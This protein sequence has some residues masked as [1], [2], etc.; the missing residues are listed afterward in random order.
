VDRVDRPVARAEP[1]PDAPPDQKIRIVNGAFSS[2]GDAILPERVNSSA[3]FRAT[4]IAAL[5][6]TEGLGS[7]RPYDPDLID[8][9]LTSAIPLSQFNLL[10]IQFSDYRDSGHK[11]GARSSIF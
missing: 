8:A 10:N 1:D 2:A 5:Y 7:S 3:R 11:R 4:G 9:D 6:S